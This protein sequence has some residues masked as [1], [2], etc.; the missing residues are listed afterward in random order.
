MKTGYLIV[1]GIFLTITLGAF[2][3]YYYPDKD[4]LVPMAIISFAALMS[5]LLYAVFKAERY[6]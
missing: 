4:F 3:G 1:L 5:T 2:A 6:I